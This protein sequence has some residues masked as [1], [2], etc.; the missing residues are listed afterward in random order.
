MNQ[1]PLKGPF[2]YKE[3]REKCMGKKMEKEQ[4]KNILQMK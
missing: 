4:V 1:C 2:A 3:K